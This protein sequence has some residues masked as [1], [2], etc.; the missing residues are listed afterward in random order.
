MSIEIHPLSKANARDFYALIASNEGVAWCA[1]A[2]WRAETTWDEWDS[3]TAEQN[4][5]VRDSII[6]SG[7]LDGFLA[8][9]DGRPV[10]WCQVGVRERVSRLCAHYDFSPEPGVWAITCLFIHPNRR[11]SGVAGE[12]LQAILSEAKSSGIVAVE[13]YPRT[14]QTLSD[15]DHWMGP[16]GLFEALGFKVV[17]PH[18]RRGVWRLYL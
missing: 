13:A 10:G 2:A 1:C 6:D 15:D 11:K 7:E 18:E 14:E 8:Y 16:P 12:M 9:E 4:R 5:A 3:R 17:H